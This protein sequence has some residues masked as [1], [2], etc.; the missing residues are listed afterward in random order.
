MISTVNTSIDYFNYFHTLLCYTYL[1]KLYRDSEN[2]NC[3][4]CLEQL[5]ISKF[6]KTLPC[7]HTFHKNCINRWIKYTK[8]S[9]NFTNCP[10]CRTKI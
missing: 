2:D 1:L 5:S 3:P 10:L 9:N 7:H 6:N 4:I 8:V